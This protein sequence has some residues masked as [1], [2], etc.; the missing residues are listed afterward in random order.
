MSTSRQGCLLES[1]IWYEELFSSCCKY[2]K[3]R[4]A[5]KNMNNRSVSLL[6]DWKGRIK[7]E[8]KWI[9]PAVYPELHH[10]N[11]GI[12]NFHIAKK[13]FKIQYLV[14][15]ANSNLNT[16]YLLWNCD[17]RNST[18]Q[19]GKEHIMRNTWWNHWLNP[20]IQHNLILG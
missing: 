19:L 4:A 18:S 12:N 2:N 16:I 1:K 7:F 8:F 10:E 13:C 5:W 9:Q 3:N 14:S 6:D 15:L 11:F 17:P 20:S